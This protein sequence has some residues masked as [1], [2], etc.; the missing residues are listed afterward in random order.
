MEGCW[1]QWCTWMERAHGSRH[2]RRA[3]EW[4]GAVG[5]RGT[6]V[7]VRVERCNNTHR[8]GAGD[9]WRERERDEVRH[10]HCGFWLSY[11]S[12]VSHP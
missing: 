10:T 3:V 7:G 8:S 6:L 2:R 12:S 9:W 5:H 4:G 11:Y 1:Q